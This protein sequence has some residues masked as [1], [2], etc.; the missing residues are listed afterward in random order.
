MPLVEEIPHQRIE[1]VGLLGE[2]N[3]QVVGEN[4]GDFIEAFQ[5]TVVINDRFGAA[6]IGA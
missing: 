3:V 2:F 6:K 4:I 1:I 5:S